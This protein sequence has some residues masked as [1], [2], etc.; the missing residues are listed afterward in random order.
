MHK[1]TSQ[2]LPVYS[3]VSL[4]VKSMSWNQFKF[5]FSLILFVIYIVSMILN[6]LSIT[7]LNEI[8]IVY[9]RLT[10]KCRLIKKKSKLT[11]RLAVHA[12]AR[13]VRHD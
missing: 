13:K 10:L 5:T 1:V 11:H 2:N 6:K 9:I 7:R 12:K 3:K 4:S 8:Q